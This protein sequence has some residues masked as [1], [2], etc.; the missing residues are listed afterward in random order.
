VE[1]TIAAFASSKPVEIWTRKNLRNT[2]WVTTRL[3]R[4]AEDGLLMVFSDST[5]STPADESAHGGWVVR[6]AWEQY[7]LAFPDA[8]GN[9]I[10]AY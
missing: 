2:G 4:G 10:G 7:K 9:A 6:S 3:D 1:A 5:L 8:I